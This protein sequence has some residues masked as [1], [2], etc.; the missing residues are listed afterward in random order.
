VTKLNAPLALA[1]GLSAILGTACRGGVSEEPPI[2]PIRGMYNQPRYD[3]Q[4]KSAFFADGRTMRPPVEGAVAR[5]MPVNESLLTG[6]TDDG[7]QWLLEVPGAVIRDFHPEIAQEDYERTSQ[8]PRR[9]TRTWDQLLPDEK[10]AARKAMMERGH[11]RYDIYC[12]PC[13][14]FDAAGRGGVTVRAEELANN[15]TD[16]G[17]AQLLPPTLHDASYRALP[18]GQIYSTITH[19]VRN[20]PAY[21]Q[22]IP[23]EDRWAIVSYVRALQL[24]QAS[25]PNR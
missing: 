18:D 6:R 8:S 25:R 9:A 17:S 20:M 22:S 10:S 16:P 7:T 12:A 3:A 4:E 13:H 23:M 5:E 19:G 21:S 14:G 2:V 24:S 11:E 1:I 15:G